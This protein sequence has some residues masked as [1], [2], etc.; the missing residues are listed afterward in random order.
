MQ[1]APDQVTEAIID[2]ALGIVGG[3]EQPQGGALETGRL[4]TAGPGTTD[5]DGA[6]C[7]TGDQAPVSPDSKPSLNNHSG[8]S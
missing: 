4:T 8:I 3:Q 7:V 6:Y 5:S 2:T 1:E